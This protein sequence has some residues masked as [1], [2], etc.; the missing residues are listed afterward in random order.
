LAENRLVKA[1]AGGVTTNLVYDPLGRL[2]QT[3]QGTS[4]TTRRFLGLFG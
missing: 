4:A 1:V 2:F 3:D